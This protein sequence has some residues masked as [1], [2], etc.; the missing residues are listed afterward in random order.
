MRRAL[1]LTL[2]LGCDDAPSES[3]PPP[4][5]SA[6][7]PIAVSGTTVWV[8]APD[9]D[10]LRPFDAETFE[11]GEPFSIPGEPSSVAVAGELVAVVARRA[12]TLTLLRGDRRDEVHVGPEP[13][14]VALTPDGATAYVTV[15]SADEVAVVSTARAE[16]VE[17]IPVGRLPWAVATDGARVVVTHRL[18]RRRDRE[19]RNVGH[20]GWLTELG[21]GERVLPPVAFGFPNVLEAVVLAGDRAWVAHQ[22]TQPAP[23]RT[24]ETSVSAALSEVELPGSARTRDLN[25]PAFSTPVNF[26]RALAVTRD[27]RTAYVVLA[28]VDTVMGID[29]AGDR[30]LGFWP[31]GTNPRGIALSADERRAF[32]SNHLSGDVSV[33][34][35]VDTVGRPEIARI[36]V[37]PVARPAEELRG[38]VLFN[39]A[40]DPRLS[41]LGWMSCASCHPD[42]GTD[43]VTWATPDGP[44]QTMP[45]WDLAG[46]EPLHIS[47]TRDEVADFEVDI[48]ALMGGLGLAPGPARRELGAPNGGRTDDL[49][50]LATF[51]R[52]GI[53]TPAAR[54]ADVSRG[55]ALFVSSDCARCHGGP[56]WTRSA[57]PGPVGSLAPRGEPMTYAVLRDVGTFDPAADV[58]GAEGFDVP[59]LL[60]LHASAPYLHDGR[61]TTLAEVLVPPHAP[62]LS[63]ADRDALAAFLATIDAT[64]EP[65]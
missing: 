47:A 63:T 25:D 59:T 20:E 51:V 54:P 45:L 5:A 29:L 55:R 11:P 65:L 1:L 7:S 18:S 35:L 64:T 30:L 23:P 13:G 37:A 16:V 32:V 14:G 38:R 6:S 24:F 27:A 41:H 10:L 53:R 19:G 28:G 62:A 15:S 56:K 26:P 40:N 61:A 46:T 33:L 31:T 50:A 17:R 4:A 3:A 43:G 42:G 9:A 21:A 34:D 48:E 2:L 12:G 39:K 57:L 60:G 36:P 22:L 49:D 44:R 58:L 8:V 52:D